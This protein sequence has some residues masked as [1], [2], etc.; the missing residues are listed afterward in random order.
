MSHATRF[1]ALDGIRCV[2]ILM[3]ILSH[4]SGTVGLQVSPILLE[5]LGSLGVRIFFVLSGFLISSLLF[6]EFS[7]TGTISIKHFYIRR[8]FRIFPAYYAFLAVVTGLSLFGI[9]RYSHSDALFALTYLSNYNSGRTW[10]VAHTWSLSVE[11]QFYLLWPL[12]VCR[13]GRERAL[14]TAAGVCLLAPV[15]R[16]AIWYWFPEHRAG[17]GTEFHTIADALATG[18]LL[19][20][21][22]HSSRALALFSFK[23]WSYPAVLASI[24]LMSPYA[25]YYPRIYHSLGASVINIVIALL[26]DFAIRE[27]TRF[28]F[29]LLNHPLMRAG[30]ALS[31]SLYLWQQPFLNRSS[32]LLICTFPWNI[33]LALTAAALSYYGVERPFLALRARLEEASVPS[34]VVIQ[35]AP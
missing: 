14:W 24:L 22:R 23:H 1:P 30:G 28:P 26:I 34:R 31:Y 17:L 32:Q 3:V 19:A 7:A 33:T 4:L 18:C 15:T 6:A 13:A 5:P 27:H 9:V 20:G 25:G 11:E 16:V 29:S 2:A 35:E 8:F 21:V 10:I 12:C